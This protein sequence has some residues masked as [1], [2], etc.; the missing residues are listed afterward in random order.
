MGHLA[1]SVC[2]IPLGAMMSWQ[3][4]I[5]YACHYFSLVFLSVFFFA[6]SSFYIFASPIPTCIL[7]F[8][9]NKQTLSLSVLAAPLPFF[10]FALHSLELPHPPFALARFPWRCRLQPPPVFLFPHVLVRGRLRWLGEAKMDE[11]S[12]KTSTQQHP[13]RA[14]P[15]ADIPLACQVQP[16]PVTGMRSSPRASECRASLLYSEKGCTGWKSQLAIGVYKRKKRFEL[17]RRIFNQVEKLFKF[18]DCIL[19]LCS[20]WTG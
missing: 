15:T 1:P 18:V 8:I 16:S 11:V 20:N 7:F 13:Q 5:Q 2:R 14:A 17:E 6:I 4:L 3:I 12:A 19:L 10:S 9:L